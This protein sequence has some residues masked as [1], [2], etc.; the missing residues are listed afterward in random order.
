MRKVIAKVKLNPGQGGYFDPITRI[1]LTHADPEKEIYAGMNTEGLK[2]AIRNRR[3]SLISGSLG[4]FTPPFKLV[5]Q[6]DGKVVLVMNNQKKVVQPAINKK[7]I[8]HQFPV[9]EDQSIK[10]KDIPVIVSNEPIVEVTEPIVG[11]Q[12]TIEEQPATKEQLPVD[13]EET[14]NDLKTDIT[15]ET[16][17]T[18]NVKYG[19]KNKKKHYKKEQEEQGEKQQ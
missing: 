2:T 8:E 16:I 3:I 4:D 15:D 10:D 5:K 19:K 9:K 6:A 7:R 1:H 17:E 18:Q 12:S 11:E 14:V 13:I